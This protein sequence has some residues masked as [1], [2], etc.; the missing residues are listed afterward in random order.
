M[1]P[2]TLDV[3]NRIILTVSGADVKWPSILTHPQT[4]EHS[5][6]LTPERIR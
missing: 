4:A 5:P 6:D 2:A 3:E 1:C